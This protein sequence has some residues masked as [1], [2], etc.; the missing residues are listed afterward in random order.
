MRIT[1]EGV[2]TE[3]QASFLQ[4]ESCDSLQGYVIG[5]PVPEIAYAFHAALAAV[6]LAASEQFGSARQVVVSG[7]V[8][9]NALLVELLAADLGPRL[10]LHRS[11]P[12]NDGGISL[13][14]AALAAFGQCTN[15]PSR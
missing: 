8:F 10:S 9:Q 6:I 2:K 12:P 11:V 3:A 1:A 15:C 13:G 4:R 7:G 5:R 14:Q